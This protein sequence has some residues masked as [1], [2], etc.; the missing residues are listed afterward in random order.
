MSEPKDPLFSVTDHVELLALWRLIAE[1]KFQP[2]PDDSDIWGSPHVHALAQRVADALLS[3][4]TSLGGAEAAA[5]HLRWRSSLSDNV[6]LPIIQ[7]NLKR[8]A[9]TTWWRSASLDVKESYVRGCV[10]P[11]DPG[12]AF[13]HELIRQ[14]EA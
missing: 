2:D 1:A 8:D 7:R 9:G 4:D 14:A 11:F 3:A 10:A 13:I 6:V 5:R 12:D